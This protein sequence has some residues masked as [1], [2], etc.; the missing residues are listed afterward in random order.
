MNRVYVRA[1][2]SKV[3][4]HRGRSVQSP[5]VTLHRTNSI[6]VTLFDETLIVRLNRTNFFVSKN[7]VSDFMQN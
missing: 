1:Y 5:D 3:R 6:L 2:T 4:S 7:K